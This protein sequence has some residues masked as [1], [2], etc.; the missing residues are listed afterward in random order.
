MNK[1]ACITHEVQASLIKTNNNNDL[2]PLEWWKVNVGNIRMWLDLLKSGRQFRKLPLQAR[3]S[4]QLKY[5]FDV[6]LCNR[7]V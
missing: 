4:T 7:L 5:T 2:Y 6:R 1:K 3:M